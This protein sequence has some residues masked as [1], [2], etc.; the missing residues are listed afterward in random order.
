MTPPALAITSGMTKMPFVVED[1]VR[2]RGGGRVRALYHHPAV[3]EVRVVGVDHAA[4]RRGGMKTSHGV[5]RN[6]SGSTAATIVA[7]SCCMIRAAH[8]PTFPKP[9][10]AKRVSDGARPC[11]GAASQNR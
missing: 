9:C 6:S 7:P 8:E 2:L 3:E 11:A 5:R 10:T 1:L 4:E